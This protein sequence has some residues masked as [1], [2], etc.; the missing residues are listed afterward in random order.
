MKDAFEKVTFTYVPANT[1]PPFSYEVTIDCVPEENN[2]QVQLDMRYTHRDEVDK[3]EIIAEGFTGDDD[4]HW[5]GN[6]PTVWLKNLNN[7]LQHLVII[8]KQSPVSIQLWREKSMKKGSPKKLQEWEYL[9]QELI[10]AIL[11]QAERELPLQMGIMIVEKNIESKIQWLELSFAQFT[12]KDE[13]GHEIMSWEYGKE[14][15]E[16]IFMLDFEEADPKEQN[17]KTPGI[18][19]DPG[20][21]L[22]YQVGKGAN[23]PDPKNDIISPLQEKI[24]K[25]LQ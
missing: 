13:K 5:Q 2:L 16:L 19:L 9:I 15:M 4:F 14:L 25:L 20:D 18:Y 10:Q 17:A 11:E 21:G 6:L 24:F 8:D 22:W 12:V 7:H 3:E 23:N 1:P